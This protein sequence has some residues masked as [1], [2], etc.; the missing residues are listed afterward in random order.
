MNWNLQ[1]VDLS[2]VTEWSKN[3]RI[4]TNTRAKQIKS[5]ID[6][7]GLIDKPIL[8][9]DLTII[10]GHQR[11]RLM[12]EAGIN[13]VDCYVC[14]RNLSERDA[15]E[16]ALS[17]NKMTAEWDWDK[18]ANEFD[19]ESL[20]AGGF[21]AKDFA[22]KNVNKKPSRPSV[23]FDFDSQEDLENATDRLLELSCEILGCK[24][25]VKNASE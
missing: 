11:I 6:K 16:L 25:R 1:K 17:L 5:C 20:L 14:D 8:N 10:G 2:Q 24:V 9:N 19:Y 23:T 7:F 3:P 12:L 22:G 15:E 13:E 18:L 21:E 4:L